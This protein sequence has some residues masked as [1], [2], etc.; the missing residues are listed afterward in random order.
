MPFAQINDASLAYDELGAH[1]FPIVLLHAGIA[2]RRMWDGCMEPLAARH[3]VVR[4]D[5]RGFGESSMPPGAYSHVSDLLGLL[6]ALRVERAALVGVSMGGR[7]VID[8]TLEHP[9]RVAALVPVA[10]AMSGY[11]DWS[12]EMEDG[13]AA[14]AQAIEAGDLETANEL[15]LRFWVD[16]PH[17]S[18]ADVDPAVRATA[19]ELNAGVLGRAGE[20]ERGDETSVDPPAVTRLAEI[21]VP[22]LV[23]V[24][25]ADVQDLL[26]IA[27]Q[28][29]RLIPGARKAV[30]PDVA[31]L[32]PLERPELFAQLVLDFLEAQR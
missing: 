32:P 8:F 22:T 17:R 6:D 7:I 12:Q 4:Y 23:V 16:G 1:G 21:R 18:P 11:Q 14:I 30:M 2:D 9:E 13:D 24:G 25:D 29:S 3:R 31:H 19:R 15:E 5:L 20:Q 28:L 26:V 10:S 27:E